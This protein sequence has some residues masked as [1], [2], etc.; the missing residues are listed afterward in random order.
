[1]RRLTRSAAVHGAGARAGRVLVA[2]D[3]GAPSLATARWVARHLAPDAELVLAHV[4]PVPRAPD[5][6]RGHLRSPQPFVREVA[7]PMR[8]GLEGLAATLGPRRGG[9]RLELRVGEPAA[10]LA[11]LVAE[12]GADLVCVGRSRQRGESV[13]LGRNTVE[14]LLRQLQ[15]PLLQVTSAPDA[16]PS[17]VLAAVDGG[18]ISERVL[19]SAWALAARLEARLTAL[20]VLDED[21]RA[22]VRAMEVSVGAASNAHAAEQALWG[23]TAGWLTDALAAAGA[24][25]GRSHAMVGHGDP[26]PELLAACRRSGADLLVMG[27][28]GRDAPTPETVGST[29]RLGLRAAPCPV[30]VVPA[31]PAPTEPF[32]GGRRGRA[33]AASSTAAVVV[34]RGPVW[35]D[36]DSHTD[37]VP[38]AATS[39]PA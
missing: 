23:A 18:A 17:S 5:F 34:A 2:V 31:A 3:F 30:L 6:L 8:G 12:L 33:R 28:S 10:E 20:H 13:K 26:G 11:A 25:P 37:D 19:Q 7:G 9:V 32:D 16:A 4:L 29:T 24:R 1:M 35:I 14:R 27:R 15:V 21:V 39:R 38:P 22:Y 36:A